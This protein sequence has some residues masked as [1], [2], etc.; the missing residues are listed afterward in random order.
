MMDSQLHLS[1]LSAH[2]Q[3]CHSPK[4]K[5]NI[6]SKDSMEVAEV[7]HNKANNIQD[8][9]KYI[10]SNDLTYKTNLLCIVPLL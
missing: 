7:I 8:I 9:K 2:L 5:Y 4:N 6:Y 1:Y 3:L 10:V